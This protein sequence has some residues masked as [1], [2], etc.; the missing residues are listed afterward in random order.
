MSAATE[1]AEQMRA[2]VERDNLPADHE[3]RIR[4]DEFDAAA[5]GYWS[6]PQTV[7][8]KAFMGAWARAR[9]AY[10]AYTGEPL[11]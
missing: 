3:L 7:P 11:I 4:A 8:V 10:C 9:R 1:L 2:I 5:A 6:E